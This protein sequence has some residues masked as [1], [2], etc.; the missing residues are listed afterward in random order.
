MSLHRLVVRL[1][2]L[3][4][5]IVTVELPRHNLHS[6]T[7]AYATATAWLPGGT[8]GNITLGGL[9]SANVAYPLVVERLRREVVH[10]R[11]ARH[12]TITRICRTLTVRTVAGDRAVHIVELATLP[13]LVNLVNQFVGCSELTRTLHGGIYSVSL[14][15]LG[16]EVADTRNLH[17][18]KY[19]PSEAGV[20]GLV[21][22]TLGD[23]D[24][25]AIASRLTQILY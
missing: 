20:I 12:L 9:R 15:L 8:I 5:A 7:P 11:N 3:H 1:E 25:V 4:I 21:T 2:H 13:Y 6:S 17:L 24:V 14:H 10:N 19:K 23:V 22:R 16:C 18:R